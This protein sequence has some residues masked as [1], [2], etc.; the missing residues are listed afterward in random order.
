MSVQIRTALDWDDVRVFLAVARTG[1]LSAAARTLAVNHTTIARR[2]AGLERD[3]GGR[4]LLERTADGYRLTSSGAAAMAE[5]E[6]MEVAADGFRQKVRTGDELVGLVRVSAVA[7]FAERR[8]AG[9]LARLTLQHAGLVVELAGEDRNVSVER[10]DADVAIRFGRPASGEALTRRVGEVAFRLYAA[11]AYIAEYPA[12]DWTFIGFT[13][14]VE[15]VSPAARQIRRLAEERPIGLRCTTLAAQREA[16]AAGGGVALLPD[17]VAAEDPRLA[18]VAA[19]GTLPDWS[20][21]VW[22][23]L[24]P[25][26]SR[27]ARVRLVADTLLGA[28]QPPGGA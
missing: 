2:L 26:V 3:L 4:P 15:N 14:Q 22:L 11:P 17:W 28:L 25:D 12:A 1:S 20:Q 21:P 24:R 16:A 18:P 9:P 10:G 6:R 13:E 23:V 8:L 7:S 19:L 5:A 27:V